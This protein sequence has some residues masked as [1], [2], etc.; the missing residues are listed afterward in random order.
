MRSRMGPNVRSETKYFNLTS[1]AV[2]CASFFRVTGGIFSPAVHQ[3][4]GNIP[5]PR[6]AAGRGEHLLGIPLPGVLLLLL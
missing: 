2:L 1:K 5:A 4:W 3:G 6:A